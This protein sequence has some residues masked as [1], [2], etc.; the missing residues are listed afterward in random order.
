M[1]VYTGKVNETTSIN[2]DLKN[3]NELLEMYIIDEVSKLPDERI[4]EFVES[5]EAKTM[6]EAGI[7]SR[8]TLVRLSKNDDL[9]R[10]TKMAAFQLAKENNDALWDQLV[11]NRVKERILIQKIVARYSSKAGRAAKIG[12][13]D[14]LKN[15][16][17]VSFMRAGGNIR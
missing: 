5:A 6:V 13:R 9:S 3:P 15:K 11:K 12:Q 14:Y 16:M 1:G 7:I 2:E 8:K 4:K 17:P 10:R